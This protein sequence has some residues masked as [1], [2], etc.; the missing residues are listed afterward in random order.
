M[1]V[2]LVARIVKLTLDKS[3]LVSEVGDLWIAICIL[4]SLPKR[5]RLD[6]RLV[7]K[8]CLKMYFVVDFVKF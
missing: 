6:M 8:A 5:R 2:V 7:E 3:C 1:F 4:F